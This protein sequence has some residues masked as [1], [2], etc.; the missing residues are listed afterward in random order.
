MNQI[1]PAKLR[2]F[3]F[4][5]WIN[6]HRHLLKPPVGNKLVYEDADMTIMVV[7][8]PNKRT[9]FHDDPVEEFFYQLEGDMV[10]KVIE[11]GEIRDVFIKQGDVFYLPP[12]VRHSPQR[13]MAGSVGLVVEP[14]RP[15]GFK[16]AFEWYCFGCGELVYRDELQLQSI[17]EDLPVLYKKFYEDEAART[18]KNCGEVHPGKEPPEGWVPDLGTIDDRNLENGTIPKELQ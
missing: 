9:D 2:S 16:D 3:N 4:Q 18:C 11:D 15:Q 13:P 10:L 1:K 8:G 14:N 17:V 6:E 7:G 12:H 5:A